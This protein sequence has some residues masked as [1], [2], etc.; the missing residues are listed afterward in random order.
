MP[1][2]SRKNILQERQLYPVL[3]RDFVGSGDNN[4]KNGFLPDR[5]SLEVSHD[6][7]HMP[8]MPLPMK[9][10]QVGFWH[11]AKPPVEANWVHL[12]Q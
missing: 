9:F 5:H 3:E 4:K 1:I 6:V 7:N 11:W 8:T 12:L 10:G 2:L